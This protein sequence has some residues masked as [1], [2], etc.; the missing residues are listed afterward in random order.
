MVGSTWEC[1]ADPGG[2]R[3]NRTGTGSAPGRRTGPRRK[4]HA[5]PVDEEEQLTPRERQVLVQFAQGLGT[6]AT[7]KRLSIS[8]ATVRNH[9]QRILAK[10]S[11]HSRIQAVALG[12][13]SGLIPVPVPPSKPR[14]KEE[15]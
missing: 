3:L 12:Y 4:H 13:A 5:R 15:K 9:S 11:V 8:R 14:S 1:A 2:G 7:A 6:D 10:L